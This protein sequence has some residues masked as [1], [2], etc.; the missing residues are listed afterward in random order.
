V[1][2]WSGPVVAIDGPAGAGKSTVARAVADRL[3]V[4]HL[5]TGAMYRS[6]TW[7][8]LHAGADPGDAAAATTVA[9]SATIDVGDDGVVVDG[10][11]VTTEIRGPEVTQAVSAV[12]SH[13]GVRGELVRR[14][15][16]WVAERGSGVLEGRDIGTVVLPDADLKIY[17]TATP[18]TRAERRMG[19]TVGADDLEEVVADIERRDELDSNREHSPLRPADD[20]VTVWT[21]DLDV[22]GVVDHVLAQVPDDGYGPRP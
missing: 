11:D 12:S 14:Q 16:A 8:V 1:T 6:I 5:D 13:P 17:L 10:I 4:P 2:Q 15:R 18:R 7:A 21:D 20:A 22:D 3:G 9:V 19:E